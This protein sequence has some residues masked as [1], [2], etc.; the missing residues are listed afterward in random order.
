MVM[1]RPTRHS[2]P[3]SIPVRTK[4]AILAILCSAAALAVLGCQNDEIQR[5]Q[6]PKPER[7][8]LRMLAAMIP[9]GDR[10]WFFKAVGPAEQIGAQ[11]E[12]FDQFLA[13]VRFTDKADA[14][15]TWTVP[16]DWHEEKG[17]NLR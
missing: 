13:S 12:A 14:P 1:S 8:A 4:Q 10:T 15:V 17:S 3:E 5:Y 9:R 2:T 11:K 7:P 16:A 6:V